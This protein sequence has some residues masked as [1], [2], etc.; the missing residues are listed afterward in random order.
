M[1]EEKQDLVVNKYNTDYPEITKTTYRFLQQ[2]YKYTARISDIWKLV[3]DSFDVS[4][5]D[6]LDFQD[7]Q[8]GMLISWLIDR[9]VEWQEGKDVNFGEIYRAILTAGEFTGS[10]RIMFESG[11]IEERLWAIFLLITDPELNL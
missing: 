2:F 7:I 4:E 9:Q 5:F 11:G 10:E 1:T 3:A 8:N 6:A